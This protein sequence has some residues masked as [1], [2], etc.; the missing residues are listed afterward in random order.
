MIAQLLIALCPWVP[1]AE[2]LAEHIE[3]YMAD[4]PGPIAAA[5]A[6]E[7]STC[8]RGLI[9]AKGAVGPWQIK[10]DGQALYRCPAWMLRR[11]AIPAINARCA[12]RIIR[13]LKRICGDHPRRWL[14]AY[15]GSRGCRETAY[16]RRVLGRLCRIDGQTE[17]TFCRG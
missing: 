10:P 9:S 6:R 14:A 12:A 13:H 3:R 2:S 16:T 4:V 8:R 5:I 1:G 7:E 17:T 11:L 15:H